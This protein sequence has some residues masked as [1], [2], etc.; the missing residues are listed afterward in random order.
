M[1][2]KA[3]APGC[4]RGGPAVL[5]PLSWL[6]GY[7]AFS[8]WAGLH[9]WSGQDSSQVPGRN[10]ILCLRLGG[11]R[12]ARPLSVCLSVL[13]PSGSPL[14]PGHSH[15]RQRE[16][17]PALR[18]TSPSLGASAPEPARCSERTPAL[19]HR[20][21]THQP[22]WGFGFPDGIIWLIAFTPLSLSARCWAF[23]LQKHCSGPPWPRG[24]Q[25]N[26]WE[27][28]GG[29]PWGFTGN[30]LHQDQLQAP[31]TAPMLTTLSWVLRCAWLSVE[32]R[33]TTGRAGPL[34]GACCLPHLC[35]GDAV[36]STRPLPCW[37]LHLWSSRCLW[38]QY[39]SQHSA[40][41]P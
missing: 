21:R 16:H 34:G 19:W 2:E 37:T 1:A 14:V 41:D 3:P 38:C 32:P 24:A 10:L 31:E 12:W 35:G 13:L 39:H 28:I 18:L 15:L 36:S 29:G 25:D 27:M 17:L 5:G 40:A 22:P 8:G 11:L 6:R 20:Q 33:V 23:S 9:R 26:P 7:R 30:S 4:N